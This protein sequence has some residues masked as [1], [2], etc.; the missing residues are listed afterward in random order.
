[1]SRAVVVRYRVRPDAVEENEQLVR[2]VFAELAQQRPPGLQYCAMRVD[3]RTFVHVAVIDG[4]TNPLESIDAFGAF[5]R[6]LAER[7]EELPQAS[8]G[9][10]VGAYS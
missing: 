3:E 10:L 1:V 7:C 6:S 2:G 9:E 4:E 8:P 5:T